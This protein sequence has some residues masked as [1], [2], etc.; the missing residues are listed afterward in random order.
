M[1]KLSI[2]SSLLFVFLVSTVSGQDAK[3]LKTG[4][5]IYLSESSLKIDSEDEATLDL[6]ILRSKKA[7]K[8]KFDTPKFLGSKDLTFEITQDA[9]NSDKYK[10]VV[11]ASDVKPG[12]YFYTVSSRSRSTQKVTGTTI[13][14]KVGTVAPVVASDGN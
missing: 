2:L 7:A 8:S 10:V 6:T 14:I 11:K 12:E 4:A 13:S 5:K 1:K 3:E 9:T